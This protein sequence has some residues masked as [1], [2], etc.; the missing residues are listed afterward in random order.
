MH[1]ERYD[2]HVRIPRDTATLHR[3]HRTIERVLVHGSA[4]E[5]LLMSREFSNP[6]F[7][8]L[9]C[10]DTPEHV[11]YRWRIYSLI[12]GDT[13]TSWRQEPFRMFDT[14]EEWFPPPL[15]FSDHVRALSSRFV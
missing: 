2:V 9:F 5:A 7:A 10:H 6:D 4:F 12:N 1:Q 14:D 8:F 13:L 3:I 11:Y 15:P